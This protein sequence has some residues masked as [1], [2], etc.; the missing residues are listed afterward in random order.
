MLN[1]SGACHGL[2][3][4]DTAVTHLCKKRLDPLRQKIFHKHVLWALKTILKIIQVA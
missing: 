4:E 2:V 3:Q 1:L